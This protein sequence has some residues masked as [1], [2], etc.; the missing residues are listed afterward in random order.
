V[1][2]CASLG[3]KPK[4]SLHLFGGTKRG[5][6]PKLRATVT[7]RAGDANFASASVALPH[8]EFLDQSHIGTVCTRVQFAAKACPAA[9]VYG[10][11]EVVTPLLGEPLRGP[12]Y[13]RSSSNPLPDLVAA[14]R[15]PDSQPIEVQVAG[16]VD[17]VHGGIRTTFDFLPDQPITSF[18]LN[19]LGGK[20]GLLVNSRNIC[21]SV[22]RATANFSGQNGKSAKL[23]PKLLN[24]CGKKRH[25]KSGK[26]KRRP[27][28]RIAV[29]W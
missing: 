2:E 25:G 5:S 4:L 12:V 23:R 6:H 14:L 8:S 26:P 28:R 20:K 15:G 27:L 19:M 9:S 1:G 7:P 11:A 21:Q 10:E 17:S 3:F 18:R 24:S 13:L 22:S 16:R 29:G